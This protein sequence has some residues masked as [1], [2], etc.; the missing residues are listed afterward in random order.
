MKATLTL[1]FALLGTIA[2]SQCDHDPVITPGE[3]ILCPNESIILS[4]QPADSYQWYK[5][6]SP[7]FNANQQNL[8]VS[9]ASDAGSVFT[10]LSTLD[11][12]GEFSPGVLVDGWAF[13]LPF[14]IHEGDE[15]ASIGG[16]GESYYCPGAFIQLTLGSVTENIQWTFNGDPIPGANGTVLYPTEAGYYSASGAP[17]E[18]PDFI[19]GLGVEIGIFFLEEAPPVIF[20]FEES[21]CFSPASTDFQW[22]L[23]GE[24]FQADACFIPTQGGV[25]TV[26]ATYACDP[27]L[28]EPFDLVLGLGEAEGN[29]LS[30]WPN[31]VHDQMNVRA[32]VPVE[33][34]WR[35]FSADG[36]TV[37]SGRLAACTDCL[38][39]LDDLGA[40]TYTLLIDQ[41]PPLRFSVIR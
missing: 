13:L 29:A 15:P 14:V 26:E 1:A 25:Y 34:A 37:S 7:L 19:M 41:E 36:R 30:S 12:C 11:E 17:A 32:S 31:P 4:T 5:D 38:F 40:G 20:Q 35:I 22:Y 27:I 6:G 18:C 9:A 39:A 24:P 33:G 10:V 28:S 3:V 21:I 23:N 2:A 8:M 16:K